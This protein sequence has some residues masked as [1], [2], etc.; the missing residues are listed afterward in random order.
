MIFRGRKDRG[1]AIKR[2]DER[3]SAHHGHGHHVRACADTVHWIFGFAESFWL[4][5]TDQMQNSN[6]TRKA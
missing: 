5:E 4:K 2:E 6:K 1:S 3:V